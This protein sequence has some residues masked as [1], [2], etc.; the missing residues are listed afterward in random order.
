MILFSGW[1]RRKSY[2][3]EWLIGAPAAEYLKDDRTA[4]KSDMEILR[5]FDARS[6]EALVVLRRN[7]G[8]RHDCYNSFV[9]KPLAQYLEN[10]PTHAVSVRYRVIYDFYLP[11]GPGMIEQVGD[12]G[13][14]NP[15]QKLLVRDMVGF[16]EITWSNDR[17]SCFSW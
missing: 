6:E 9:S 4:V 16:G 10:L 13:H 8:K 2:E 12:F 15:S 5:G 3:M 11:R 1:E 14:D 7:I 17:A